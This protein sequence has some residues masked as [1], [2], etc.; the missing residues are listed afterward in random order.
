MKKRIIL[1]T[2]CIFTFSIY[3]NENI[4]ENLFPVIEKVQSVRP[5]WINNPNPVEGMTGGIGMSHFKENNKR[6]I[7]IGLARRE[8]ASS[9]RTIVQSEFT[10]K[11]DS[12]GASKAQIE[13]RHIVEESISAV[14]IDTWEDDGH[15]YVWMA[16]F[17]DKNSYERLKTFIEAKN[18]EINENRINLAQYANRIVITNKDFG[19]ITLNV[20]KDK[21]V[22]LN[23]V[24]NVYRLKA[25]SVNPISGQVED[26]SKTKVGDVT[27]IDVL[28][29][30]SIGQA[31]FIDSFRIQVGDIVEATGVTKDEYIL[32]KKTIK[33]DKM[34]KYNYDINYIPKIRNV[35]RA[36]SFSTRQYSLSA[37]SD[38][39]NHY[40]ES[41]VGLFRFF[42]IGVLG[43][44][45]DDNYFEVFGKVGFPL[46]ENLY[47]GF[48]YENR[49]GED[50]EFAI[51]MLE[52]NFWDNIGLSAL[53]YKHPLDSNDKKG[54]VGAS[55]QLQPHTSVIIG[56]E[57]GKILESSGDD[58]VTIKLNL[59]IMDDIWLG[60]GISWENERVYFVKLEY[61]NII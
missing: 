10:A 54:T 15:Y 55:I 61:I 4:V 6:E 19:K 13:S 30:S 7:A 41:R 28:D 12:T 43:A 50:E 11:Q 45:G 53:N 29:R 24:Y 58:F 49:L 1:L 33:E 57:G 20:G 36:K 14:L 22:N 46:Y 40:L 39:D 44:Q 38:F 48:A 27:I 51:S 56:A 18:I 21:N 31:N 59:E 3:A 26:F 35:E 32:T 17:L 9:K 2:L 23:E 42:E 8:I 37:S 5:W 34:E 52:L 16:E 60:G 47:V 25:E